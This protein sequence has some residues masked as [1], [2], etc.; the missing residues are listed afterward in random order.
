MFTVLGLGT[1]IAA[2]SLGCTCNP[3]SLDFND[4]LRFMLLGLYVRE[5]KKRTTKGH[6][7]IMIEKEKLRSVHRGLEPHPPVFR[8]CILPLYD[9]HINSEKIIR[10]LGRVERHS[11]FRRLMLYQ[12]AR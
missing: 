1:L 12:K 9:L 4:S 10:A 11:Q 5:I 3:S 7:L 6:P 8:R 2:F